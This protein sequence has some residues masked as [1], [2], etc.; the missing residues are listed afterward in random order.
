MS[1]QYAKLLNLSQRRLDLAQIQL[2]KAERAVVA[3][4]TEVHRCQSELDALNARYD[5][6][7]EGVLSGFIGAPNERIEVDDVIVRLRGI[8]ED[9]RSAGGALDAA[10]K[11]LADADEQKLAAMQVVKQ[12][13]HDRERRTKALGPAIELMRRQ[14]EAAQESAR[15]EDFTNGLRR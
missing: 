4:T 7:R 10:R 15:Q 12:A 6:R 8:D 13:E 14:K 2:A 5:E 3:A 1:D 11:Q 9:I